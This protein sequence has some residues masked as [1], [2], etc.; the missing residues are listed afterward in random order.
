MLPD[1]RLRQREYLLQISRAMNARL[2]LSAVLTLI[3]RSVV[4]LLSGQAGLI[5]LRRDDGSFTPR[6]SIGLPREAVPLFEPLWRD[7]HAEATEK[8]F[9]DLALRL[10]LASRAAGCTPAQGGDS[11]ART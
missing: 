6:A 7:V 9:E 3:L 11:A 10:A 8:R 5:T 4:E 1:Y 2:D